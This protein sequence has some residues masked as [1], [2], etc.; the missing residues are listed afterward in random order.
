MGDLK[1]PEEEAPRTGI[2]REAQDA[3]IMARALWTQATRNATPL[4]ERL[5]SLEKKIDLLGQAKE[6]RKDSQS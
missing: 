2:L 6:D 3:L 1:K 5:Q 4:Q